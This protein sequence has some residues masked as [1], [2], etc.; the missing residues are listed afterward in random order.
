LFFLLVLGVIVSLLP[1]GDSLGL[2]SVLGTLFDFLIAVLFFIGQLI[3]MLILFVVSLPFLLWG[4]GA[5]PLDRPPP[6]PLPTLP[7]ESTSPTVP[8]ATWMLFRSILL[9]GGLTVILVFAIIQFVRQHGGIRPALQSLRVT[10]WLMLAWQWLYRSAEKTRDTLSRAIADSWQGIVSRWE[11]GRILPRPNLIRFRS[12][13]T[14]RQIYF[15]YL[16]MIRRGGEQG[17]T[18]KPSQ[19][20]SEYAAQLEQALP[21]VEGDIDSITEA[22]VEARYSRQEVD[23]QKVNLV[24]ETW[25]RIRRA[26]QNKARSERKK[27]Q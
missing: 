23:R 16:A 2:L 12:L 3:I 24:K 5:G 27:D 9:W 4:Q 20:P 18:R 21:T 1:A 6:P 15:F 17:V 11:A 8:S 22:F 26:L 10:N 14:R 19:T 25:E 13:D 7:V